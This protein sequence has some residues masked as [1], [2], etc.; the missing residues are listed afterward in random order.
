MDVAR[1]PSGIVGMLRR[2]FRLV[3]ALAL[4]AT[5]LAS[6]VSLALPRVYRAEARVELAGAGGLAGADFETRCSEAVARVLSHDA[7]VHAATKLDLGPELAKVEPE[8]RAE[9]R[10]ELLAGMRER[11][12]VSLAPAG[13]AASIITISSADADAGVAAQLAQSL[14]EFAES[15]MAADSTAK[16]EEEIAVAQA[17][18]KLAQ[19]QWQAAA[20]AHAD[21]AD[22]NREFLGGAT[23][24]LQ[25]TRD[26]K[27]QLRDVTIAGL[28]QRKRDLDALL[29]D[30]KP[31]ETVM[32][33]QPDAMRLAAVNESI[34]AAHEDLRN[35]TVNE[36]RAETDADVVA[37]RA[38]LTGLDEAKKRLLAA[39]PLMA[40][41]QPSEQWTKLFKARSEA[42]SQLDAASR[43]LRALAVAEK[44]HE[45]VARRT[46]ELEARRGELMCVE[47][48][49][50]SQFDARTAALARS[51]EALAARRA[52]GTLVIRAQEAP[53]EP[54]SP[55]GPGAAVLALCGMILGLCAGLASAFALE[56]MDH[57]FREADAVTGFLGVPTIGAVDTIETP[58]EAARR[59]AQK[60]RSTAKLSALAAVAAVVV[61]VSAFGS[62]GAVA[63]FVRSV[64]G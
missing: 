9:R 53:E 58:A 6:A 38:R 13:G 31:T 8:E 40:T 34:A 4:S 19:A 28:E 29:K 11:T 49:A 36:K 56:S 46:P 22:S 18:A 37:L 25:A 1:S 35:L 51:E 26:Q 52:R 2:R 60:R 14:A 10:E 42:Q 33:P 45:A 41:T 23:S 21:F 39:A 5:I 50:K 30:E 7:F 48:E 54:G 63:D 24:K 57:S 3:A 55:T 44:D 32:T 61:A 59:R 12:E 64:T 47:T 16:E 15:L 62:A 27:K 43:Q 17:A 20:Q